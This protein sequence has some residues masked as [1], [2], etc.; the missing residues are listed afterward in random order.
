MV[1]PKKK[2]YVHFIFTA[3]CNILYLFLEVFWTFVFGGTVYIV[4]VGYIIGLSRDSKF[5]YIKKFWKEYIQ[6]IFNAFRMH[7]CSKPRSKIPTRFLTKILDLGSW[8]WEGMH[9]LVMTIALNIICS[10]NIIDY[11]HILFIQF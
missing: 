5:R 3:I 7:S 8:F 6:N 9:S 2:N 10:W 4:Q 1:P 11:R